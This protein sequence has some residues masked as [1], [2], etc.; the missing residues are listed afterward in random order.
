MQASDQ[1]A[2]EKAGAVARQQ[3]EG[4]QRAAGDLQ[5]TTRAR[6]LERPEL[7][8]GAAFAGG[9]VLA[10]ILKGLARG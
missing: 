9:L 4:A 6:Y 2:T 5:D 3:V 10:R 7:F 8:V 1:S